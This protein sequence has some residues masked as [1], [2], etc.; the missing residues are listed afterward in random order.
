MELLSLR[1]VERSLT[2]SGDATLEKKQLVEL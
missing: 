2:G 1:S